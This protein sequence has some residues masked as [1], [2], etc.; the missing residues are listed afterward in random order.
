[1]EMGLAF[2]KWKWV[3]LFIVDYESCFILLVAI[4]LIITFPIFLHFYICI[5]VQNMFRQMFFPVGFYSPVS[6]KLRFLIVYSFR[7]IKQKNKGM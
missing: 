7:G 5:Y 6:P 2:L 4:L 1:M 3:L